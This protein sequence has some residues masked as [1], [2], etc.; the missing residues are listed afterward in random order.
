[1]NK[2]RAAVVT[3]AAVAGLAVAVPQAAQAA[4]GCKTGGR[5]YMCEFGITTKKLPDG[6]KQ[7]SSW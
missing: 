4:N 7:V 2:F 5:S 1:M 3:V 6:T